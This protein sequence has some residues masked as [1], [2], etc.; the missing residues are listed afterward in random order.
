MKPTFFKAKDRIKKEG[1]RK[2]LEYVIPQKVAGFTIMYMSFDEDGYG[3]K[4]LHPDGW[5]VAVLLEG[6][7]K[8]LGEMQFTIKDVGDVVYFP[9]ACVHYDWHKKGT[10]ILVIR[11][12]DNKIIVE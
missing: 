7:V 10:K 2:T 11:Q 8:F 4:H 3:D 9:P 6:E 5:E 12:S 1:L